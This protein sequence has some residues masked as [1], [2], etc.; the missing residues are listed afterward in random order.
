MDLYSAFFV[1][2]HTEGAQFTMPASVCHI[3]VVYVSA[4]RDSVYLLSAYLFSV[5]CFCYS[6]SLYVITPS[7]S[8]DQWAGTILQ[9]MLLCCESVCPQNLFLVKKLCCNV[10]KDHVV[11]VFRFCARGSFQASLSSLHA[12]DPLNSQDCRCSHLGVRTWSIAFLRK[13]DT[14]V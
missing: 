11:F 14:L 4:I 5:T 7:P 1:V 10:C 2:P 6:F 12:I 13:I 8:Y 3:V 9:H